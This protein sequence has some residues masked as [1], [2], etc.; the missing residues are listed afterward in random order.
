MIKSLKLKSFIFTFYEEVFN[1]SKEPISK[2]RT[3]KC[4][5]H[6]HLVHITG[7]TTSNLISHLG[8]ED[9]SE[10]NEVFLKHKDTENNMTPI[11]N[12]KRPRSDF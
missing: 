1:D 11:C 8:R 10:D 5:R 9:Y 2:K 3:F 12:N 6:N 4:N 7:S